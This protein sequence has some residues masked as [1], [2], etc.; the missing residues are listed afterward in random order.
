MTLLK[1]AR[2]FTDYASV[3][4]SPEIAIFVH[5][6]GVFGFAFLYPLSCSLCMMSVKRVKK[7]VTESRI[8]RSIDVMD[9]V[10]SEVFE[11]LRRMCVCKRSIQKCGLICDLIVNEIIDWSTNGVNSTPRI[12]FE[13][14]DR[15]M[16]WIGLESTEMVLSQSDNNS[17]AIMVSAIMQGCDCCRS[18]YEQG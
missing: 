5:K 15:T 6:Y 18:E 4:K 17:M 8:V 12:V 14:C 3:V 10:S 11:E 9:D 16:L 13:H 1:N 2:K 7:E